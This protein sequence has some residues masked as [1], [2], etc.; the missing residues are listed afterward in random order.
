[1]GNVGVHADD[2][3]GGSGWNA[4]SR[5]AA[6]SDRALACLPRLH[7]GRHAPGVAVQLE[8]MVVKVGDLHVDKMVAASPW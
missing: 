1:M 7:E 4:C 2:L 5:A 3:F 6:S 8:L